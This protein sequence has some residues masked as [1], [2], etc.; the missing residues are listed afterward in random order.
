MS[1]LDEPVVAKKI[2]AT[3][4]RIEGGETQVAVRQGPDVGKVMAFIQDRVR[5]FDIPMYA[6]EEVG[7]RFEGKFAPQG[8]DSWEVFYAQEGDSLT[9]RAIPPARLVESRIHSYARFRP[10]WLAHVQSKKAEMNRDS[11]R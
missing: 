6:I 7:L 2:Y 10:E 5:E 9:E 1:D 4:K 3:I 8:Y 11:S